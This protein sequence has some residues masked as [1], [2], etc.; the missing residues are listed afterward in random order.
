MRFFLKSRVKCFSSHSMCIHMIICICK[1]P[2]KCVCMWASELLCVSL[3]GSTY[4]CTT[5][6]TSTPVNVAVQ[7]CLPLHLS[8]CP[9]LCIRSC[10]PCVAYVCIQFFSGCLHTP[11]A[12]RCPVSACMYLAASGCICVF[13]THVPVSTLRGTYGTCEHTCLGVLCVFMSVCVFGRYKYILPIL[14]P[15]GYLCVHL[16]RILC[17]TCV[18]K[19]HVCRFIFGE[20]YVWWWFSL[21]LVSVNPMTSLSV[22]CMCLPL[23]AHDK[24]SMLDPRLLLCTSFVTL[25][26]CECHMGSTNS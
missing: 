13:S 21:L 9:S 10:C 26:V 24:A 22:P 5:I 4:S 15:G 7:T 6:C 11:S 8:M 23:G 12:H 3:G 25:R 1:C 20:P 14:C 19:L 17:P 2:C 18:S 16:H